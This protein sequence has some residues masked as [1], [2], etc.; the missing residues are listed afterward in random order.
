MIKHFCL[1]AMISFSLMVTATF[2][3]LGTLFALILMTPFH[4]GGGDAL[5]LIWITAILLGAPFFGFAYALT[6]LQQGKFRQELMYILGTW[7]GLLCG[8]ALG[9]SLNQEAM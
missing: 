2:T 3:Q 6:K 8:A 9:L 7:F 1:P 4:I 5:R